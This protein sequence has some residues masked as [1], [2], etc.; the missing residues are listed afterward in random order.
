MLLVEE[1]DNYTRLVFKRTLSFL[2]LNCNF[3]Q[4]EIDDIPVNEDLL[5]YFVAHCVS[6]LNL[7]HSTIKQYLCGIKFKC[8]ENRVHYPSV[9]QLS[10]FRKSSKWSKT[11]M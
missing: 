9:N 4:V 6:R 7:S 2:L 10:G 1:P 3:S 5:I 11:C 8:Q